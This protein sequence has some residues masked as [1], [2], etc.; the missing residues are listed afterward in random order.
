M[1]YR[2][3]ELLLSDRLEIISMPLHRLRSI[4][5]SQGAL[6]VNRQQTRRLRTIDDTRTP[7]DA[8]IEDLRKAV[9]QWIEDG[10][11]L[12]IGMDANEDVRTGKLTKMLREQGLHN[13]IIS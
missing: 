8:L 12:I 4:G 2:K 11:H 10:E 6:S 1:K 9:K 5:T 3:S 7:R 13:A